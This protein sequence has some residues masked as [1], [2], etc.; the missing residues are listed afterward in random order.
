MDDVK[1]VGPK[2]LKGANLIK[3]TEAAGGKEGFRH[4]EAALEGEKPAKKATPKSPAKSPGA[5]KRQKPPRGPVSRAQ[6]HPGQDQGDAEVSHQDAAPGRKG[7]VEMA[8]PVTSPGRRTPRRA[9]LAVKYTEDAEDDDDSEYEGTTEEELDELDDFDSDEEDK[10]RKKA[11]R[12]RAAKSKRR[13]KATPGGDD[14]A[15][16]PADKDHWGLE[17]KEVQADWSEMTSPSPSRCSTSA[18]SSWT[19]S[20]TC[21][22]RI[23]AWCS[24][25]SRNRAGASPA[26][27]PW[28][29]FPTSRTPPRCSAPI[30]VPTSSPGFTKA[31]IT[32]AETFQFFKEKPTQHWHANRHAVAQ[33]FLDR[34][35]RQNIAEIDEIQARKFP[36]TLRCARRNAPSTS[37]STITSRQWT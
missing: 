37:S 31:E 33:G 25:S 13:T 1:L 17:T 7:D 4:I 2:R 22:P 35:V 27:R 30:S 11:A 14:E 9:S 24:V 15:E 36:W 3:A 32:K 21:S 18:A 34:F 29:P 5:F 12:A 26:R 20:P 8:S 16:E 10:R 6:A 19:S 23:A 28:A